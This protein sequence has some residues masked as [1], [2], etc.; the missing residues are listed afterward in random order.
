MTTFIFP[1]QGSQ[2]KGMGGTLFSEFPNE[3]QKANSILGYSIAALCLED[4]NNQLNLTNFTQ[5]AL[6]VVNALS[7][8]K[9]LQENSKKPEY[10]AGHSLGEYSALFAAGVYDFETGLKLVQ[11]RGELMS[12]ATGGG[13]AAVVGLKCEA[14]QDILKQN[15]LSSVSIANYNSNLQNIISGPKEAITSAEGLFIK[16]GAMLYMP[17]KVSGAF[18]SSFMNN[19]QQEFSEFLK[20]FQFNAP[21]ITVIANLDAKPYTRDN[22]V[23]NLTQQ[24]NNPVLWTQSIAYLLSHGETEFVE[25]GPGKVLTGLVSKIQK[26]Q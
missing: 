9:K 13:M 3:V 12:K 2:A 21:A 15:N 24:I 20:G 8:L 5:P 14:V 10:M 22:I 18:H 23:S 26:G 19:A 16:A 17:L 1:G 7:Y 25:I 11:K 4:Q 6:Y